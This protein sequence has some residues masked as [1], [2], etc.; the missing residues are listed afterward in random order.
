MSEEFTLVWRRLADQRRRQRPALS[1][2]Q[3]VRTAIQI[4]DAEGVQAL[5]MRRVATDLG[6]GTTSLYRYVTGKDEL[7]ELMV[8]AVHGEL[9][10]PEQPSEDWRVD[11]ALIAHRQ[12]AMALRHPWFATEVGSRPP[13]G[14]QA[15]RWIEFALTAAGGV[16]RDITVASALL[17]AVNNYVLGA[18]VNELS[19]QEAQRRTGLTEDQWRAVVAPYIREVVI[20]S[21]DFPEATRRIIDAVDLNHDEQFEIGLQCLLDGIAARVTGA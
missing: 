17:G 2:D 12:R 7:L 19:E 4:A 3:I 21:G 9:E 6:S 8:D 14:P 16:S 1:I 15:L 18:A 13:I 11:L 20:E 10:V 5:T